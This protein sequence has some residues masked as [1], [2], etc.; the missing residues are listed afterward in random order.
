[1]NRIMIFLS[2]LA[3]AGCSQPPETSSSQT[4]V[5]DGGGPCRITITNPSGS[6]HTIS[7]ARSDG[8]I[9]V[10]G[11]VPVLNKR[12]PVWKMINADV[13]GQ[14]ITVILDEKE[15]VLAVASD[16][17]ELIVDVGSKD[18]SVTQHT[19]RIHWR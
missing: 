5:L 6:A 14:N 13:S 18:P 15:I 2:V 10:K 16:T 11:S 17:L 19:K 1:M 7:I 9:L 8:K 12:P 4:E 3:I